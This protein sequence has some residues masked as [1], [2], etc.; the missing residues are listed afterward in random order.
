[1]AKMKGLPKEVFARVVENSD[2]STYIDAHE[3]AEEFDD[4]GPVGRYELVE[5][6]TI[7]VDTAF[8]PKARRE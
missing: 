3:T 6:G 8:V 5:E 4:E 2:D 7:T 1:M